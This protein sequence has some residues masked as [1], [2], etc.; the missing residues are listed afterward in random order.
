[1]SSRE[2]PHALLPATVRRMMCVLVV[3]ACSDISSSERSIP[4]ALVAAS[5][6]EITAIA[7]A[8][9]VELPAVTVVNSRGNPVAG[10]DVTFTRSDWAIG[11]V[12]ARSGVDGVAR[13]LSWSAPHAAGA[14]T[15]NA[16]A[17]GLK[18]VRFG[19]LT[20]AGPAASL[21]KVGGDQQL[22]YANEALSRDPAVK[23]ADAFGNAVAGVRVN[24]VIDSGDG[25][26]RTP[27]TSSNSDG[28]A[29]AVGWTLK[30]IGRH[31][32]SAVVAGLNPQVFTAVAVESP[33]R[34]GGSRQLAVGTPFRGQLTAEDCTDGG[35]RLFELFGMSVREDEYMF[36]LTSSDFDT[37]LEILDVYGTPIATNDNA[38][39][40][41]TNSV[42]RGL[43]AAGR[44]TAVVSA[45]RAAGTGQFAIG[46]DGSS[47]FNGCDPVF[48]MRGISA[49]RTVRSAVCPGIT[50]PTDEF[51]IFLRAGEEVT[52]NILD[53]SYS[54][55]QATMYDS[56]G[57]LVSTS[58]ASAPYVE[59]LTFTPPADGYYALTIVCGDTNATY[60]LT[61]R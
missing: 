39:A 5:P 2:K 24:F 57:L 27:V 48:T 42:I 44:M 28:V 38:S 51:R 15:I 43:F 20:V 4:T 59:T 37:G 33:G 49:E 40:G 53:R 46:Y 52:V 16:T 17:I 36:S 6:V 50:M 25:S 10:I 30:S 47:S 54:A 12:V 22:G 18:S 11:P 32:L 23:I 56:S 14:S 41:S 26:L 13:V 31:V 8:P 9:L 3:T 61:I 55:W 19:L 29:T 1:M 45:A 60:L 34:C 21:L 35:G 7:G 58:K